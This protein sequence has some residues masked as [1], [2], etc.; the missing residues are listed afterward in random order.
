[1]ST[2]EQ[3]DHSDAPSTPDLDRA[4]RREVQSRQALRS[5]LIYEIVRRDGNEE[6]ERPGTSLWWSGI[7]AGVAISLSLVV[8]GAL[9]AGLP[10][11]PW[12]SLVSAFGYSTGFVVVILGRLQ[13]FTE[14]TITAVLPLLADRSLSTLRQLLRMWSIVFAANMTG[15]LAVGAAVTLLD[16]LPAE[17]VA[18]MLEIS[19]HLLELSALQT[20]LYGVPA[21]FL[22][23]AIVWILPSAPSSRL[24][25]IVLLTYAIAASGFTHVVAGSLDLWLLMFEGTV[26]AQRAVFAMLLPTLVG[27]II[28]GTGLF[29]LIA[30]AQVREEMSEGD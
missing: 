18:A 21:G 11:A 15:T 10:D 19:H 25:V 26:S 4:D 30:W 17:N 7:A 14:N 2:S 29:A 9:H 20:M 1:M 6:L 3:R 12:R 27:N 8:Q 5:P 13:L 23:A 28:G 22:V 24:G 16:A